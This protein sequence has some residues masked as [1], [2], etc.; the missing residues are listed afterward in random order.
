MTPTTTPS[1]L[2]LSRNQLPFVF[3]L[4]TAFD[5]AQAFTDFRRTW[6]AASITNGDTLA[7][8]WVWQGADYE[9]TFEFQDTSDFPEYQ[10]ARFTGSTVPALFEWLEDVLIPGVL[11]HPDVSEFFNAYA[12]LVG[13]ACQS[14]FQAREEY[15]GDLDLS[16]TP[17]GFTL[18]N[19][20]STQG[21]DGLLLTNYAA[22]Y[23]LHI[24]PERDSTFSEYTR[25]PEMQGVP[26]AEGNLTVDLQPAADQYFREPE[27][28]PLPFTLGIKRLLTHVRKARLEYGEQSGDPLVRTP[29][30]YTDDFRIM[31]G[32][33]SP[34]DW[35]DRRTSLPAY[36]INGTA[37]RFLTARKKRDIYPGQ[38][39]ILNWYHAAVVVASVPYLVRI[40][41]YRPN[42]A[43]ET[44]TLITDTDEIIKRFDSFSLPVSL[45]LYSGVIDDDVTSFDLFI[46]DNDR[47]PRSEVINYR[48]QSP[49]PGITYLE[50]MNSWGV[51]EVMALP[52]T[53]Q[54]V[55]RASKLYYERTRSAE[56]GIEE[57]TNAH[58]GEVLT[59]TLELTL[60][61]NFTQRE[62]PHLAELCA[63][64]AAYLH[65]GGKRIPCRVESGTHN[66]ER[67]SHE[68]QFF[69]GQSITI[70][71]DR[72][73]AFSRIINLTDLC[74]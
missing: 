69:P 11:T 34:H 44:L 68:G 1:A 17:T 8:A 40:R 18:T 61:E 51:Q 35:A 14:V 60:P 56:Y 10:I 38:V 59:D 20:L 53:R 9:A 3:D 7:L 47:T 5:T 54:R 67:H 62:A 74:E 13:T 42:A 22:R 6:N 46:T 45:D 55:L 25:L 72:S 16:I 15:P 48:V 36:L 70:K 39:D 50:Y 37:L 32:G 71:L 2:S 30:A 21:A 31:R 73:M 27:L 29:V 12:L 65:A 58:Y 24:A 64:S 52:W 19:T 63:T 26:D 57:V 28:M 41:M 66:L 4:S 23:R 49:Q 33:L 43:P